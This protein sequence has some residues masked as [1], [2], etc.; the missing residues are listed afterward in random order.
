MEERNVVGYCRVSTEGQTGE[1]KY[2]IDAQKRDIQDYCEKNGCTLLRWYVEEAVSGST[3]DRDRPELT[4]ILNGDITNPPIQ[5]VI[6]AK[7]DRLARSIENFYGFKYLLKR[8]GIDLI[9]VAEDFGEVGLYK[10]I[11]EAISAAFAELERS[12]ITMRMTSGRAVKAMQGGYAG[13]K[14]PFGYRANPAARQ[15]ELCPEEAETVRLIFRLREEEGCTMKE[16]CERLEAMG[17]TTR[18]GNSFHISGIQSILNNRKTYEGFY[19]YGPEGEWVQGRH[20]PIL[21]SKTE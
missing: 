11:Y 21:P 15:Y 1:D 9:S 4:K 5:A 8:S 10:P 6:V 12:F 3:D 2:G 19:K 17:K 20:Q 14:P 7:N 13:G 18:K 16:I